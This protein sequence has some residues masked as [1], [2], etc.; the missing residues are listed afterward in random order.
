MTAGQTFSDEIA[1]QLPSET[2]LETNIL[3]YLANCL[4][5]RLGLDEGDVTMVSPTPPREKYVGFD[6]MTGL[7]SGRYVLLQFKRPLRP[8]SAGFVPFSITSAQLCTL[9]QWP[10]RSAFYVLPPV[11]SNTHM[12]GAKASLLC[13]AQLVDAWDFVAG[14]GWPGHGPQAGRGGHC[15]AWRSR[16]VRVTPS[17]ATYIRAGLSRKRHYRQVRQM[18]ACRL[19]CDPGYDRLG[20][21]VRGGKVRAWDGA[22]W[23]GAGGASSNGNA[24][25]KSVLKRW[26]AGR[27][28]GGVGTPV[29]DAVGPMP[30]TD[31]LDAYAAPARAEPRVEKRPR[32]RGGASGRGGPAV[33]MIGDAS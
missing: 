7:P 1:R 29:D 8:G 5:R 32:G 18:S 14:L 22:E 9:L 13:Q 33:V 24:A 31:T 3:R 25:R 2:S 16:T 30:D 6:A 11:D 20:F 12:W 15:Q 28:D 19:C 23:G 10:P 17:G 27:H 21:V 4:E 26:L